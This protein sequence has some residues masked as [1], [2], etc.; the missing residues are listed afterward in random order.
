MKG[1]T[2]MFSKDMFVKM[3]RPQNIWVERACYEYNISKSSSNLK[4]QLRDLPI[5]KL[6]VNYN[7]TPPMGYVIPT[8]V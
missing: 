4:S 6:S 8:V 3:Q 2:D 5:Q 7:H 1:F